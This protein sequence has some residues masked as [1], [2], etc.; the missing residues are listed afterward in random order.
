MV[1]FIYPLGKASTLR[2]QRRRAASSVKR[3][4]SSV[5]RQ[6]SSVKRQVSSVKRQAS[7]VK[8]QASSVKRQV[9]SVKRQASSALFTSFLFW[10]IMLKLN[11]AN[12][13]TIIII[14][15]YDK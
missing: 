6:A 9:S 13:I 2:A 5:K 12:N 8:R 11:K 15:K 10:L 3:Q 4:A 1:G 7:S 14:N